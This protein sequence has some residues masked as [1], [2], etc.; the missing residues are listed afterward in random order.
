CSTPL[1]LFDQPGRA[2]ETTLEDRLRL[3][4]AGGQLRR[5]AC[6]PLRGSHGPDPAACELGAGRAAGTPPGLA[7]RLS[8]P[9]ADP[10]ARRRTAVGVRSS[11]HDCVPVAGVSA[12]AS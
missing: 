6:R 11:G 10:R 2:A 3:P 12:T 1:L 5:A 8:L 9:R 4:T 7:G